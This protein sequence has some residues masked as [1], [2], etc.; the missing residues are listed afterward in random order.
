MKANLFHICTIY[1]CDLNEAH[2]YPLKTPSIV[3]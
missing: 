1:S 3:Q 2:E